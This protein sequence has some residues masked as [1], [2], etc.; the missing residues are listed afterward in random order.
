MV[1]YYKKL[2][3]LFPTAHLLLRQI[4]AND[5]SNLDGGTYLTIIYKYVE[6]FTW[7]QP[8]LDEKRWAK[9]L[10]SCKL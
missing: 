5:V 8:L 1:T 3:L 9:K 2:S 4:K 7:A 10:A 6:A